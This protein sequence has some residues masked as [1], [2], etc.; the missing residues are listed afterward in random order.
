MVPSFDL[1]FI[2]FKYLTFPLTSWLQREYYYWHETLRRLRELSKTQATASWSSP[3]K[4]LQYTVVPWANI[5]T[6][7]TP[8]ILFFLI[9]L[10]VVLDSCNQTD[11]Q[12][13]NFLISLVWRGHSDAI[14]TRWNVRLYR[15]C[16]K[17]KSLLLLYSWNYRSRWGLDQ[18]HDKLLALPHNANLLNV[19]GNWRF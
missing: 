2:R 16:F 5:K 14:E 12:V 18:S 6:K 7:S 10:S 17:D 4:E 8:K 19:G 3:V 13:F 11:V 15:L 9:M 1:F